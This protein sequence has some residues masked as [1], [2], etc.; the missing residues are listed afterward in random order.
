MVEIQDPRFSDYESSVELALDSEIQALEQIA[1][2]LSK[3]ERVA[4]ALERVLVATEVEALQ[5]PS[6]AKALETTEFDPNAYDYIPIDVREFLLILIELDALLAA[7]SD[8]SHGQFRYRP[9]RFLEVGCG[10]GR[11]L[12]IVRKGGLLLWSAAEGIDIV[13]PYVDAARE[14]YNLGGSVWQDDA[15]TFD[16]STYDVIFSRRPFSDSV[17]QTEFENNLVNKMKIGSYLIA[18]LNETHDRDSRLVGL[19]DLQVI[20]KRI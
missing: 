18:P 17:E 10:P 15:R 12:F 6:V 9:V 20:W 11:N 14:T 3:I 13:G 4:Q 16:Y 1:S 8:Y 7:D 5:A 19:D 2:S